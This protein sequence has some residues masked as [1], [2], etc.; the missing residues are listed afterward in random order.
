MTVF[1]KTVFQNESFSTRIVFYLA[2]ILWCSSDGSECL[3]GEEANEPGSLERRLRG[4][5]LSV[6]TEREIAR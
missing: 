3:M 2:R 1:P 6:G 4:S 5:V